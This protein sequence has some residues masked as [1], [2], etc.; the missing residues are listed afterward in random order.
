MVKTIR[1]MVKKIRSL[2][3]TVRTTCRN[4]NSKDDTKNR[5]YDLHN[6]GLRFRFMC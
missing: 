3:T 5:D 1:I 4:H 6:G 2:T